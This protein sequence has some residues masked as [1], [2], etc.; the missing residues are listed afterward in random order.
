MG[1]KN[2]R[3]IGFGIQDNK[4]FKKACAYAEGAIIGS[5]FIRVLKSSSDLKTDI[6]QFITSVKSSEGQEVLA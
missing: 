5:A 3:L 1:L 4:T 6:F 2:P